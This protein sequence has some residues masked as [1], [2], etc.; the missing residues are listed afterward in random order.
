MLEIKLSWEALQSSSE[1]IYRYCQIWG[2]DN[3]I[4]A[5]G[6]PIYQLSIMPCRYVDNLLFLGDESLR[7]KVHDITSSLEPEVPDYR[8]HRLK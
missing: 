4:I 5:I 1:Q 2:E 8:P 6:L 3:I 7:R